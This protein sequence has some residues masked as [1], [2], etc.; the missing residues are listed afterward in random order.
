MIPDLPK[1]FTPSFLTKQLRQNGYLPLDGTVHTVSPTTIGDGTGMMAEI[2][3]LDL[4]Y[5]GNQGSAPPSLIA[6]FASQTRPT[7][8]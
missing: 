3:K 2:A 8:K 4:Q 5:K 7:E 1:G 6:K